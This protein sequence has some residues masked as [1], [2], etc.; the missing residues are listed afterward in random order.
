MAEETKVTRT[1]GEHARDDRCP[2]RADDCK[3]RD[4]RRGFKTQLGAERANYLRA[5]DDFEKVFAAPGSLP[6]V[7]EVSSINSEGLALQ[8]V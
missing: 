8:T 4:Y 5:A 7:E 3:R 2:S 6:E 1:G